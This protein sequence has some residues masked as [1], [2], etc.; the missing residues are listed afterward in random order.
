MGKLLWNLDCCFDEAKAIRFRDSS[1]KREAA[2]S[3]MGQASDRDQSVSELLL[4]S[5]L[6]TSIILARRHVASVGNN[7]IIAH[8]MQMHFLHVEYLP[9]STRRIPPRL[10]PNIG[11]EQEGS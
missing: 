4:K 11:P 6:R 1:T 10:A 7:P 2:K 8:S 5:K 9:H 3:G